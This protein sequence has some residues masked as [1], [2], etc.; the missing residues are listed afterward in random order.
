MELVLIPVAPPYT[1]I[2]IS[3]EA[4]EF[5]KVQANQVKIAP[6]IF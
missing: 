6:R 3:D 4:N 5:V 1:K 2:V